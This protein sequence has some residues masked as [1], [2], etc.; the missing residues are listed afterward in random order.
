MHPGENMSQLQCSF[1]QVLRRP[2]QPPVCPFTS[3]PRPFLALSL[4][5]PPASVS[6][7][8]ASV[9]RV[10]T[11]RRTAKA[12]RPRPAPSAAVASKFRQP[13]RDTIVFN[14][15]PSAPSPYYTP[16]LFLPPDDPRRHLL[17]RSHAYANPYAG[18][19]S[20]AFASS[21]AVFDPHKPGSPPS[22]AQ[23]TSDMPP[24]DSRL[25]LAEATLAHSSTDSAAAAPLPPAL[26][27]PR[28]KKY[29]LKAGDIAEIRRLRTLD[30]FQWTRKRLAEKFG[31]TEF[32]VGMCVQ[33]NEERMQW[34]ERNLAMAKRRWG[35][36][37]RTA[38]EE[39]LKRRA[40]WNMDA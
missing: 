28:Q 24:S 26:Q 6:L 33:A 13:A 9:R 31:C 29:H 23:R 37:R 1:Q 17:A 25:D 38:R 30:P 11:A 8:G 27:E 40:L 21:P 18:P 39:R 7:S 3:Q 5:L 35:P 22:T 34:H 20:G 19:A 12:L 15:P 4:F 14:P 36:K 10:A 16:P 32:F 2:A